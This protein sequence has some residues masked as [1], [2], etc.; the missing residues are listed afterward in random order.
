[1][2]PQRRTPRLRAPAPAERACSAVARQAQA[3]QPPQPPTSSPNPPTSG[4]ILLVGRL[5]NEPIIKLVVPRQIPDRKLHPAAPGE[6]GEAARA[7]AGCGV[8]VPQH[9]AQQA[10][11]AVGQLQTFLATTREQPH[12]PISSSRSNASKS[13]SL[14]T[15]TC[16]E[17]STA[18]QMQSSGLPACMA[19]NYL[20]A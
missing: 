19:R 9:R 11:H 1:M 14:A 16:R 13:Y 10:A 3:Q 6:A 4:W 5:H 15:S 20:P 2:R 8:Q 12:L 17:G 7:K 18:A